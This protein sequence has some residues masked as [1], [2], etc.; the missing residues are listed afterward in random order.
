MAVW[1]KIRQL[2]HYG[3]ILA[4][5]I[6]FFISYATIKCNLMY[7]PLD[8]PGGLKHFCVFLL[9]NFLTLYN[10]FQAAFKGPG[11]VPYEWKPVSITIYC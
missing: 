3:P 1:G 2:I 10:Y 9:W 4:L 6:I 11:F 7:W 8:Y 5:S